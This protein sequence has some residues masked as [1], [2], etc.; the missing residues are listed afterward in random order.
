VVARPAGGEELAADA[1]AVEVHRVEAVRGGV[2]ARP[3]DAAVRLGVEGKLGAHRRARLRRGGVRRP[4]RL[5][6]LRRAPVAL[7]EQAH[8][9]PARL[10]PRRGISFFI[11][12]AHAPPVALAAFERWPVVD[13]VHGLATPGFAA[14]PHVGVSPGEAL[15][16][17]G[18]LNLVTRLHC[19]ARRVAD[20]PRET[21]FF[22]VDAQ[23]GGAVLDAQAVRG[24]QAFGVVGLRPG[25]KRRQQQQQQQGGAD[26]RQTP[27]P[28]HVGLPHVSA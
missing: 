18:N 11:P 19:A 2:E 12:R 25:G 23:R 3:L 20:D 22:Y 15:G 21:R 1:P 5:D 8:L 6:P 26:D 13:D 7:F 14:V 4:R 10:A 17:A 27:F 24:L 16:T 28:P 9:P